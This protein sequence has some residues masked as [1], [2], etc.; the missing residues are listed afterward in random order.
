MGRLGES[1]QQNRWIEKSKYMTGPP[2]VLSDRKRR[3]GWRGPLCG[4]SYMVNREGGLSLGRVFGDCQV[5]LKQRVSL[6]V[7]RRTQVTG[8]WGM[9]GWR[10]RNVAVKKGER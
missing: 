6:G 3:G 2:A 4:D 1:S 5:T 8:T 7:E 9:C 10:A